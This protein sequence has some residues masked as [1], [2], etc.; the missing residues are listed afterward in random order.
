MS[1]PPAIIT[2]PFRSNAAPANQRCQPVGIDAVGVQLF[3][4]GSYTS[5][6]VVYLNQLPTTST[7]PSG[8]KVAL[9]PTNGA[10]ST[11]AGVQRLVAGS[12]SSAVAGGEVSLWSPVSPPTISTLPPASKVAVA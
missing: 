12:Y 11:P 7:R 3:A 10:W 4:I 8:S 6:V 2:R 9:C 5:A 1:P